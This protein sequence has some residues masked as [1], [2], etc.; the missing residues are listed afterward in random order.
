MKTPVVIGIDIGTSRMKAL[1]LDREGAERLVGAV[2]TPFDHAGDRI[3]MEVESL[4]RALE[5]LLSRLR[6]LDVSA[7]GIA[8]MAETGAALDAGGAPLSPIISWHDP[9]GQE[10]VDDLLNRFGDEISRWIGQRL[11]TVS[12]AAKLGWLVRHGTEDIGCWLGA[13]ELALNLLTG[14]RSTE[15]SLAVRTGWYDVAERRYREDIAEAIGVTLDAFPPVAPAGTAMGRMTAEAARWSPLPEGVPVT[16]AGH[17]HLAGAAGAGARRSDVVNS[18]GTAESVLRLASTLPDIAAVLE[19][20][21]AL[22]IRPGGEGY[23]LLA[24]SA[25]AGLVTKAATAI[26]GTDPDALD[27][28]AESEAPVDAAAF[29]DAVQSGER[30]QVPEG[31]RG[32]VWRGVLEALAAR[33][34][35][36]SERIARVIGGGTERVL[37]F[38]GGS[39]SNLSLRAKAKAFGLDVARVATTEAPA[40]GAALFA[41]VAA[42]WWASPDAAPPAV[43]ET[44]SE[45]GIGRQTPR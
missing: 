18:V 3:E 20:R 36:A 28:E 8:G 11:R 26:L 10:V 29:V 23:W 40:R 25:R 16:I 31:P 41:G 13:P 17:D 42:G 24:S 32:A 14:G 2:A 21:G 44:L 9:R 22:S 1:A 39:R 33:T 35:E 37:V 30:P 43:I 19:V 45:R 5:S 38:G 4:R 12:S 6:G 34:V 15:H 7:I 27:R